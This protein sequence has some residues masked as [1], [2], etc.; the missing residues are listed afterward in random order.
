VFEYNMLLSKPN[1][2]GSGCFSGYSSG[3]FKIVF[4]VSN[5]VPEEK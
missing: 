4:N 5:F 1:T 2:S 3:V